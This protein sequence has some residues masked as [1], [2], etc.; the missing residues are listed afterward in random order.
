MMLRII[1][2]IFLLFPVAGFSQSSFH[3]VTP[4]RSALGISV[5][6]LENGKVFGGSLATPIDDTAQLVFAAGIG[7]LED[8][9]F[10]RFNTA[11]PPSPAASIALV[12]TSG[13]G[14]TGL[15]SFISGGLAVNSEKE[16]LREN[17]RTIIS[18]VG[19][20]ASAGAGIFKHLNTSSELVATPIIAI[21]YGYTWTTEDNKLDDTKETTE[22][23]SFSGSA[24]L[25]LDITP[26]ISIWSLLNFSFDDPDTI[27]SVGFNWY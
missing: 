7:L 18:Q 25:Q 1:A 26:E 16:V 12:K 14:T 24:G 8:E 2:T 10:E 6:F 17:N 3:N 22:S 19:L 15:K 21:S 13:L 5:S 9:K 23:G 20:E 27:L 11:I 4:G